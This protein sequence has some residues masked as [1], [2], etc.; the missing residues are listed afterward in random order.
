M[1]FAAFGRT[2]WLRDAIQLLAASGH[3][4]VLV[5]TA[6][7][8]VEYLCDERD[9]ERLAR[10]LGVRFFTGASINAPE[11]V[12]L[13]REAGAEVAISVNWPTLIGESMRAQFR[14]GIINA[15]AGDLPRFRGNACPNWAILNGESRVVLTLH[16]MTGEL[17]AGPILLQREHPLTD[18]TYI[19]EIY[20]FM[21]ASIP[22]MFVEALDGLAASTVIPRPQPSDPGSALRTYPRYPQ[23]GYLD[24]KLPAT[25]LARLVRASA[26]PFAGAFFLRNGGRVTVW[27]ARPEPLPCPSLGVPGQVVAVHQHVGHVDVLTGDG[28][29]RLEEIQVAGVQRQAP[30]EMIRST[31]ERLAFDPVAECV[32]LGERVAA[33]ERKFADR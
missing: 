18:S 15:H 1:K 23:D 12:A 32:R 4:P 14:H 8:S 28:I 17:D 21:T 5:G 22:R 25:M 6:P 20:A 13:A 24:W 10:E 11:T 33:L 2:H 19:G 30:A 29:L 31:R 16:Q 26:E 9:F 27:R 7:A 3:H